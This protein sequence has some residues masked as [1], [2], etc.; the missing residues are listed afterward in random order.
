[1]GARGFLDRLG[2]A[3]AAI[4]VLA[5]CAR[6]DGGAATNARAPAM[7]AAALP[8]RPPPAPPAT[9]Q[10]SD[11]FD[12]NAADAANAMN[13]VDPG[14]ASDLAEKNADCV[15]ELIKSQPIGETRAQIINNVTKA[16]LPIATWA[17]QS[18]PSPPAKIEASERSFV[19][20]RVHVLFD[21]PANSTNEAPTTQ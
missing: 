15:D 9:P 6:Q 5:G 16:C 21:A 7:N 1:M 17:L 19:T 14:L 12:T 2:C 11:L 8:N 13:A 3:C 10:P 4:A 18:S 20:S